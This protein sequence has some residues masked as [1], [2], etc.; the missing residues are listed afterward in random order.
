MQDIQNVLSD[1][2]DVNAVKSFLS[3]AE[4]YF[5]D[6]I[7][8]VQ[9]YIYLN[10][11][12]VF[13]NHLTMFNSGYGIQQ[14]F[15]WKTDFIKKIDAWEQVFPELKYSVIEIIDSLGDSFHIA[16]YNSLLKNYFMHNNFID[17]F[18]EKKI[19]ENIFPLLN[20]IFYYQKDSQLNDQ[21]INF[22]EYLSHH[23]QPDIFVDYMRKHDAFYLVSSKKILQKIEN[24]ISQEELWHIYCLPSNKNK[25]QYLFSLKHESLLDN[26][27]SLE[28]T[29]YQNIYSMARSANLNE[30]NQKLK[31]LHDR[32]GFKFKNMYGESFFH[33]IMAYYP[34]Y[35][36]KLVS[37]KNKI[38][39]ILS[40]TNSIGQTPI[41]YFLNNL[42][43]MDGDNVNAISPELW[44]I[45]DQ[46]FKNKPHEFLLD[47][48]RIQFSTNEK[49]AMLQLN[50]I[51]INADIQYANSNLPWYKIGLGMFEEHPI[52]KKYIDTDYLALLVF[53]E[54][55][56]LTKKSSI[57]MA[58]SL[59]EQTVSSLLRNKTDFN[60]NLFHHIIFKIK[61]TL[62][63]DKTGL[64]FTN[65]YDK[66]SSNEKYNQ[67]QRELLLN[68]I[69]E[70]SDVY[71]NRQE[72]G[73]KL[74]DISFGNQKNNRL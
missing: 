72:L 31:M 9:D 2:R 41:D 71:V 32:T 55:L 17:D 70:L 38:S 13:K 28:Y 16:R 37:N 74:S 58:T 73:E 30:L 59:F 53:D 64:E 51:K 26:E 48:N 69:F 60:E 36:N 1:L 65:F 10:Y 44:K 50:N 63:S 6:N 22:I 66:N 14:A 57:E 49:K 7:P 35:F 56:N 24:E 21:Y 46:S 45:V 19:P 15:E 42:P 40:L 29:E 27:Q 4:Q 3:L 68:S 8:V 18:L 20:N 25:R 12:N 39:R 54:T 23:I 67:Q 11:S 62:L 61:E 5:P 33:I 47:K 52:L 34:S 43:D